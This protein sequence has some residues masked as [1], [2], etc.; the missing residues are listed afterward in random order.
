MNEGD[1]GSDDALLG[2]SDP[3]TIPFLR[4]QHYTS[5]RRDKAVI[6][7]IV[8][9]ATDGAEN[10]DRA[11]YVAR[12]FANLLLPDNPAPRASAHYVLDDNS[13]MQ[14]VLDKDVAWHAPG[15]NANGIGIEHCGRAR[16]SRDEWLDAFGIAMLTISA[17]LTARLCKSYGIPM[18]HVGR[19][20]LL[21]MQ[22][23]ITTHYEV[24][25]AFHRST[26][27][28]PGPHFPMDWYLDR[29]RAMYARL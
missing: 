22:S 18:L 24:N 10:H 28:D 29:V 20:G 19:G 2:L 4:A 17:G 6:R 3:H 16:Q 5:S 12:W 15:A 21:S 27:T 23:G 9:H 14:M 11:E 26:H 8:V 25:E 7:W 1:I 13:I